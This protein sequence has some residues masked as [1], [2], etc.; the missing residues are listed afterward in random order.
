VSLCG[1]GLCSVSVCWK[2]YVCVWVGLCSVSV[3][4]SEVCSVSASVFR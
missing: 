2:G 1:K 3:C 4:G